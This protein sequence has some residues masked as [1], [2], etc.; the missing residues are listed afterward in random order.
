[1]TTATRKY[2]AACEEVQEFLHAWHEDGRLWFEAS[3]INLDYDK[4]YP[5]HAHDRKRYVAL[6]DGTSGRFILD[7]GTGQVWTISAYGRP[8][9]RHAP[10][11]LE[12]MTEQYRRS[13]R[14]QVKPCWHACLRQ[15]REFFHHALVAP[16]LPEC[17][18]YLGLAA[19]VLEDA[20]HASHALYLR[21]TA[22]NLVPGGNR[23]GRSDAIHGL[24]RS[25]VQLE[26]NP[27][28]VSPLLTP[29]SSRA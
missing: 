18:H 7:A 4:D 19:D 20:G 25:L 26:K 29:R 16:A 27:H 21:N 13:L 14:V 22:L 12:A 8:N 11:Q 3:Y 23:N 10:R 15:A 24:W 2:G 28:I 9:R 17:Q 6:D 1:M 5:K